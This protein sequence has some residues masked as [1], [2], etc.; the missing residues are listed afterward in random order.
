ML[1]GGRDFSYLNSRFFLSFLFFFKLKMNI[2]LDVTRYTFCNYFQNTDIA[3]NF[4]LVIELKISGFF[5]DSC[6]IMRIFFQIQ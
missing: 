4:A 3:K 6:G 1:C 2:E 5:R